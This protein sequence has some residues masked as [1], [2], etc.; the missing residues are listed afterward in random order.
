MVA[1]ME[2]DL[3]LSGSAAVVTAIP[4][5]A[6]QVGAQAHRIETC[7]E[8]CWSK[9]S[10]PGRCTTKRVAANMTIMSAL[11]VPIAQASPRK[12]RPRLPVGS[13]KTGLPIMEG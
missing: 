5:A 7:G 2:A 3:S 9:L 10:L 8:T 11:S 6:E 12:T 1:S 4:W 13:K